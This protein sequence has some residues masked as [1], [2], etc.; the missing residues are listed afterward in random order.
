[1]D[2]QTFLSSYEK[3][4]YQVIDSFIYDDIKTFLERNKPRKNHII[5]IVFISGFFILF[6]I[7]FAMGKLWSDSLSFS[8]FG[9]QILKCVVFSILGCALII[10]VHEF[11]H[12]IAYKK[13]GANDVRFGA[14]WKSFVFYAAAHNFAADYKTFSSC[15]L[16]YPIGIIG[17]II[18]VPSTFMGKNLDR[19][20]IIVSHHFLF[21]RFIYVIL[22]EAI[23]TP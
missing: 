16:L 8:Q 20:N 14:I 18:F 10:P 5:W 2:K 9:I 12:W 1:M 4:G 7:G 11:I 13:E 21:R 22:Y 15:T 6:F 19:R 17:T 3:D 23:Q